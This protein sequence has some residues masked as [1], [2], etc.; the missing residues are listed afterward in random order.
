MNA[1][2]ATNAAAL[3][4]ANNRLHLLD[5]GAG[6]A[7]ISIAADD[8]LIERNTLVL[9]PFVE[10]PG[11]PD[12]G[13]DDNPTRDPADPCARSVVL[14]AYPV[15]LRAYTVMV[16]TFNLA[17]LFPQRPY[18]AIGGIHVRPGSER[19][20]IHE[21]R[22]VGGGGN[23]ITLG[24]DLDP[25][26]LTAGTIRLRADAAETPG[27]ATA[28]GSTAVNVTADGQFLALVQDEQGQPLP[29][30]DLYLEGATT[31]TDRSD[32]QGMVSIRTA[33]GPYTLDVAPAY[34]ILKVTEARDNGVLVNA[35]TVGPRAAGAQGRGF[36]HEIT[37]E[38][39]DISMMGM[40]GIGFARRSGRSLSGVTVNIPA[41]DAKG[42]L[43]AYIDAMVFNLALTP[44][45]R[46]TDLVRDLVILDN[47]IH[48]NLRNPFTRRCVRWR[49]SSGAAA[50]RWR[51][52]SPR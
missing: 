30:V 41:N 3:T 5:T 1:I 11:L 6:R 29:D 48:D 44:L 12:D 20:R 32:A 2:R 8:V 42:A 9:M 10:T 35:V 28:D 21:N 26:E 25:P 50:S 38:E 23:G 17:L 13:P 37:I 15:L 14:Y 31:A 39:N 33:P 40:S 47:R 4:I 45:L 18:H 19:V 52:P 27:A 24:G 22:I 36:L 16:W 46:A 34:R 43:L 49:S 7:T 51:S